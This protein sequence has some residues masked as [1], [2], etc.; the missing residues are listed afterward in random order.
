MRIISK[1]A[2]VGTLISMLGGCYLPPRDLVLGRLRPAGS[3]TPSHQLQFSSEEIAPGSGLRRVLRQPSVEELISLVYQRT[4][5]S[6]HAESNYCVS[7]A[8]TKAAM[9][10]FGVD[11]VA[12]SITPDERQPGSFSVV[13]RNG[14]VVRLAAWQLDFV[15]RSIVFGNAETGS[16]QF[17][18]PT[19]L[20]LK[21]WFYF[22]LAVGTARVAAA[23]P[24]LDGSGRPYSV[25]CPANTSSEPDPERLLFR[26]A[27]V[28]LANG[29]RSP[30]APALLGLVS[31]DTGWSSSL[32]ERTFRRLESVGGMAWTSH[33]VM[34][35]TGASLPH[36]SV[37]VVDRWSRPWE[38]NEPLYHYLLIDS[39]SRSS[40]DHRLSSLDLRVPGSWDPDL[41]SQGFVCRHP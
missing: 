8:V 17:P 6:D 15:R 10:Q 18:D 40:G 41:T 39:P 3:S 28:V 14:D 12:A 32:S 2:S 29:F 35:A 4:A 24:H 1:A 11:G 30:D 13:L 20:L 27:L 31:H 19:A 36:E 33:H 25:T 38:V 26:A 34:F 16:P 23:V 21:D 5:D 7:I 22:Y 9:R 37:V